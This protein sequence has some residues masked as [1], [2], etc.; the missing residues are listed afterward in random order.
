MNILIIARGYPSA[1]DSQW[2]SFEKDQAIA[3]ASLGHKVTILSVDGRYRA[4]KRKLGV[5]HMSE[6]GIEAYNIY[7]FPLTLFDIFGFRFKFYLRNK[8]LLFL[9]K[10]V[11]KCQNIPDVI[12][13]HYL[14]NIYS[15]L[16]IKKQY[17]IPVVGIEHWSLL[18]KK[19]IPPKVAQVCKKTYTNTNCLISVSRSLRDNILFNFDVDS[20]VVPNMIGGEFLIELPQKKE[21]ESI[22]KF[23]SVGSLIPR[24]GYDLLLDAF[25]LYL[26]KYPESSLS[27]I[28]AGEE[29]KALE[30][31]IKKAC[32]EKKVFLLGQKNK[33]EIVQALLLSDFFVLASRSET[34]GVVCIEALSLG[35][36]VIAT[37][38]GGPEH[39]ID[40]SNGIIVPIEDVEKLAFA[41]QYVRENWKSY[42]RD[43]IAEVCRRN[44]AP[45]II[46]AKLTDVFISV[47]RQ[48]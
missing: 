18:A 28:G 39:F 43:K 41:L 35:L 5:S 32:L 17:G 44:Y 42:D 25:E 10:K 38:C 7:L 21:P 45:S 23:I 3:L 13:A 6:N 15:A 37:E 1:N 16:S 9:F 27:I 24:K 14:N 2:G 20:K 8:M 48:K 31:K 12:Y 22:F 29:M 47:V 11:L 33:E 40:N 34:F 19:K 46:A 4:P 26:R 30:E 36:P